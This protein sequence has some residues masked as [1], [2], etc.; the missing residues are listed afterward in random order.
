[1]ALDV[2]KLAGLSQPDS[3]ADFHALGGAAHALADRLPELVLEALRISSTVA[4]GI[5]GRRRAGPGETFWQFRQLGLQDP[6]TSIDWRR[7]ASSDNLYV[8]EREWEAAHTVWLW[9]DLSASMAFN[10]HLSGTVKR[11]RAVVLALAAAELLVAGGERVGLLGLTR[12]TAAR[13][14]ATKLAESLALNAGKPELTQSLPPD[15]RIARFSGAILF[16][17][18]LDPVEDI[19]A[20]LRAISGSDVAG[21][22]VQIL[23]PAEETLPYEGRAEF[24]GLEDGTQW[25]ADRIESLRDRYREKLLAHR[26]A[27]ADVARRLGWTLLVHHTD[28]PAAEPLLALMQRLKGDAA[29]YRMAGADG[30][31]D[32]AA[33]GG[34]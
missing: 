21:H 20:R 31:P 27:L 13:R 16:S 3:S 33:G 28:R 22:L 11:D 8:R 32:A 24:L 12:P 30:R 19:A 17:D 18:F 29:D 7:S 2:R 4:H 23:D 26:E 34:S 14:A 10:S 6:A 1:M 15:A 25:I 9:P 5:H